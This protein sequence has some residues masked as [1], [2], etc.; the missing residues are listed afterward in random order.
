MADLK[1]G[2][3]ASSGAVFDPDE[4]ERGRKML[5][6]DVQARTAEA[7]RRETKAWN[8]VQSVSDWEAFRDQ[9]IAALRDS[10]GKLPPVPANFEAEVTGGIEGDGYRIR[11]LIYETRPGIIVTAHLYLPDPPRDPMPGIQIIHAHHRPKEQAEL[12]DMGVNWARTGSAVL[13]P[14]LLGHGER[15]E[16]PFGAR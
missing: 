10:L 14:D 2:L 15:R 12:Q 8:A 4:A 9:R 13:I 3:L 7:V 6:A 16:D 1:N 11:K 5:F